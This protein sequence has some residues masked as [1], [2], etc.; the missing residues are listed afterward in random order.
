[1]KMTQISQVHAIERELMTR[2]RK[3]V[4]GVKQDQEEKVVS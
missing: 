1:M 2:E 4:S 3:S